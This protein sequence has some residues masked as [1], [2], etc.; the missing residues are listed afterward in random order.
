MLSVSAAL[1]VLL[2]VLFGFSFAE[3]RLDSN[4]LQTGQFEDATEDNQCVTLR[5]LKMERCRHPPLVT[6]GA[7]INCPAGYPESGG[8]C[9]VTC[10]IG[11]PKESDITCDWSTGWSATPECVPY[12][13]CAEATVT[14][15]QPAGVY[16]IASVNQTMYC[17]DEGFGLLGTVVD[18]T[19]KM[20]DTS[21]HTGGVTELT[22]MLPGVDG[23]MKFDHFPT[24]VAL[25]AV[26]TDGS[27][28]Y[29]HSRAAGLSAYVAGTYGSTSDDWTMIG[30][31][32]IF[33]RSHHGTCGYVTY[34]TSAAQY[35]FGLCSGPGVSSSYVNHQISFAGI[36]TM[37][38]VCNGAQRS[39]ATIELYLKV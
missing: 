26:C 1:Q 37:S 31:K 11:T 7:V 5:Q 28:V 30:K 33:S 8:S 12:S 39:G 20:F 25:K 3:L 29:T 34:T 14:K 21:K 27:T 23:I 2:L 13:S 36:S 15:L 19:S 9:T 38:T 6:N 4:G 22:A 35:Q 32:N 16:Y 18:G 17:D 24:N 10:T